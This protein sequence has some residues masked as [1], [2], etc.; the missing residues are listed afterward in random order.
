MHLL[1]VVFRI[2]AYLLIAVLVAVNFHFYMV[3]RSDEARLKADQVAVQSA[4][5]EAP[6]APG[7]EQLPPVEP[8]KTRPEEILTPGID[9]SALA[10]RAQE[11]FQ[12]KDY[13]TS[14]DLC[15]QLA[16]KN[17]KAPLCVGISFFLM[18]DYP[19]AITD[20]EKALEAGA[21]EY[22]CRR[23]LAFAY[24]Y[25][26]DFDRGLLHAEKALAINKD[27]ELVSFHARLMREK[28]AHRNFASESTNHFKVQFD[29]YE[30]G[31]LSRTVIG[32]LEDAYSQIGRDL[33]YYPSEPITVILYTNQDFRDVTHAP[34]WSGGYF[35]LKDGKIRVPVRGAE[36]KEALLK[37]VLFHEYVHALIYSIA[38]SCP[39]W[40]HEGM[41]EYYS[42]G[43][44]Q[45]VGQSIPLNYL[46]NSFG[47]RDMR[48]IQLAYMQSHS[49]VSYLMEKFG[50]GRM[51]DMLISL[52]KSSDL[53]QAFTMAFQMSY[54][55]FSEK[56]GK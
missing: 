47:Q 1:A 37:T 49:A 44:S 17:S 26:H 38:K 31:G 52:S 42:K 13:K 4:P 29:G 43:P 9:N 32:I 16:E 51:K 19:H 54:T 23:Y 34:G 46:D 10:K 56:W 21:N 50:P 5:P 27:N 20:L 39:L 6:S 30:H 24:Y 55:E 28:N 48:L 15:R 3:K 22:A 36:G 53:N 40:V 35:D 33:D 45:R 2:V 41:A 11:S 25:K 12:K 18:G 7:V 14:A 8:P